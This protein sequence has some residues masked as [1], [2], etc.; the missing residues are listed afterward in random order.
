[1]IHFFFC[2]KRFVLYLY[3]Q[4]MQYPAICY[5]CLTYKWITVPHVS[6]K[7]T[8]SLNTHVLICYSRVLLPSPTT[9]FPYVSSKWNVYESV[10][11]FSVR[12]CTMRIVHA[13][14]NR[15]TPNRVWRL[16]SSS[17]ALR[18]V[19]RLTCVKALDLSSFHLFQRVSLICS[20]IQHN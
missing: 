20:L 4:Y 16:I 9:T 10:P 19:N 1:M 17:N 14:T 6:H 11:R 18:M 7:C 15:S 5:G 3:F 12:G 13:R 2:H 8:L